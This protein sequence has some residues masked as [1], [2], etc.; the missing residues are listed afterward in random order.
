MLPMEL[1]GNRRGENYAFD[2]GEGRPL[3]EKTVGIDKGYIDAFVDSDGEVH[4]ANF[5]KIM[6]QYSNQVS[7]T[8]RSRNKF[9]AFQRCTERVSKA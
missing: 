8:G 1:L 6:T 7:A 5:G 2:K 9:Y 3:G 4:G